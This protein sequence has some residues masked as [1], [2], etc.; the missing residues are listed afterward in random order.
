M[1]GNI[2]VGTASWSDPGFIADWY[3]KNMVA[4]DRLP[5]YAEHFNLVELNSSFYGIPNRRQVEKWCEQTPDEFVFDVK[6]HKFLSRHGAGP[7]N[8][9]ADL[10]PK[11][12][13]TEKGKL[14]L[15]PKGEELVA[16]RFLRE[17]APFAEAGKMGALLL[18]LSPSFSPR[19]HKLAELEHLVSLFEGHKLAVELRNRGW[20]TGEQLDHTKEFFRQHCLAWV[21]VDAPETEHFMAMPYIGV[22]TDPDLGYIRCH[23]RNEQG[24]IRGRTVAERFN[25][26]YSEEELQ[27]IIEKAETLAEQ[28]REV[29][30]VYNNNAS[31]Y[32]I[33][34]AKRTRER[35]GKQQPHLLK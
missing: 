20:V 30:I 15:S 16:K 7:E 32:A 3:P 4:S 29:H 35:L 26:Q 22:V 24:Y 9:P 13:T 28:A 14:Q 12:E 34:S 11:L 19:K 5:Y 31:D 6:L 10:R 18:Q 23:G 8:L 21:A 1:A 2:L 27:E 25:Y 33:Q 17:I